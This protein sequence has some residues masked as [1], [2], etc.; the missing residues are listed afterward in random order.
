MIVCLNPTCTKPVN[1]DDAVF[2]QTCGHLL[3][4]GD[5]FQAVKL[6]GQGGFGRTFLAIDRA[7]NQTT[8]QADD[9]LINQEINQEINQDQLNQGEI[10]GWSEDIAATRNLQ[11]RDAVK[12]AFCIIKQLLPLQNNL[13]E[14][15]RLFQ[16]E[17]AQLAKLGQ[18]PQ[19]PKL[20]AH[21]EQ[22]TALY[23]V[24][25]FIPGQNLEQ[26]LATQSVFSEAQIRKLLADL[27]PVLRFIHSQQVV[28]RDIKPANIIWPSRGEQ[29]VLVDFGAAKSLSET[30]LTQTGTTIGSAGYAAPEQAMGKA[31]FA[32]DLYSLGVTCVHLLTGVHPFDL[33]SI[34]EDGWVWRQYL[35]QPISL[36]L[37]RVLDKLLQ[38][39]TSQRYDNATAVLQDLRLEATVQASSTS[40]AAGG[41]TTSLPRPSIETWRC[42]QTLTGHQGEITALAVSPDSELIASGSADKTI[43][44]WSLETGELLYTWTGRSFRHS[45]GHQDTI[46]ALIFSPNSRVL[47]SSSADGTIKQWDLETGEL[48]SSLPSHGWGVS[49]LA[50]SPT[51]PL[52]VSGSD[53]GLI[54]LWDLET[55]ALI[56]TIAQLQQ[57]ILDLAIDAWGQT[58]WSTN[59]K[60]I[61]QWDLSDDRL[62]TTLKAHTEPVSAIALS[63]STLISGGT[64]KLIKLWNL[65]TGQQQKLIAAHR[66]RIHRLAVRPK[67]NQFASSS[68]DGTVKLWDI[69][70]GQRLA[71]LRHGWSVRVIAFSPDGELLVSGSA[72]E[73]IRI[74]QQD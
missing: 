38:R 74:W 49:A 18:H 33:Y 21:F 13:R 17:V 34:S 22:E 70:T 39:A 19:I 29:F 28:H 73:A 7:N 27:L 24:Q 11:T 57:P 1:P 68:E 8:Q 15:T 63:S 60:T 36:E 69:W 12:P 48:F 44:L 16:Q 43:Q 42:V 31:T 54:Q 10:N 53:D 6:I 52:L 32:S 56:A 64:D 37:R 26:V 23:L 47:I 46:T 40:V 58:V 66:Q 14:S 50:L 20:L 55:E 45:Q 2:C 35:T 51:E 3:Q 9:T 62:L 4:L 41:S 59:G 5:R 65:N 72:D 61:S 71:T 30:V 67:T 25:E